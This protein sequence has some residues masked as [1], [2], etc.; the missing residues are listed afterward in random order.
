MLF[1][2][3]VAGALSDRMG[4]GRSPSAGMLVAA[5]SF[6]FLWALPVNFSYPV[7][8]IVIVLNG[9]GMG[10]FFSPNRASDHEQPAAQPAR[11]RGRAWSPRS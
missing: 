8:A 2:G 5:L 4:P 7:F 11:R 3:P 6:V 9:L 10:I 1:A